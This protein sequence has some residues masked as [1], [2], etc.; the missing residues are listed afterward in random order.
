MVLHHSSFLWGLDNRVAA[1]FIPQGRQHA[2]GKGI[3]LAGTKTLE[4]GTGNYGRGHSQIYSLLNGPASFS[5]IF[6]VSFNG[7]KVF[8]F[9]EGRLG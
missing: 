6:H 1:E 2:I 7:G 5:G 9:F 3:G 4:E 8:V